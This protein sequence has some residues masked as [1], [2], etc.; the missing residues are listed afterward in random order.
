MLLSHRS[1]TPSVSP[2]IA[3]DKLVKAMEFEGLGLG[4]SVITLIEVYMC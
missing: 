1:Q 3:I 2:Q 4:Q